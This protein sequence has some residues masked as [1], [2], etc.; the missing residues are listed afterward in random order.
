MQL[1]T[2]CALYTETIEKVPWGMTPDT[3]ASVYKKA[4]PFSQENA[5]TKRAFSGHPT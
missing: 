1:K 4:N 3:E 2:N 5:C